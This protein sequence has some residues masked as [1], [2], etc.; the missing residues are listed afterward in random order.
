MNRVTK[1]MDQGQK[2]FASKRIAYLKGS[3]SRKEMNSVSTPGWACKKA[4]VDTGSTVC[5]ALANISKAPVQ[6][7][8]GSRR[9]QTFTSA[10]GGAIPNKG[11]RVLVMQ[12]E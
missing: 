11:E 2:G 6:E 3:T 8:E 10:D 4:I 12:P 7:S 5:V 9:G 1:K